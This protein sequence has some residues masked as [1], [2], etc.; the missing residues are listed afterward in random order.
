MV[1]LAA[2]GALETVTP[3]TGVLFS[4]Q[5]AESLI[6]AVA[7]LDRMSIDPAACRQNAERFSP[8]IFDRKIRHHVEVLLGESDS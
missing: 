7:E 4:E 1:A 3:S 6:E 8:E 5:D 2:G